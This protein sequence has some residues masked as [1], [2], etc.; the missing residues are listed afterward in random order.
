MQAT[1]P[2]AWKLKF[3][4]RRHYHTHENRN[5]PAEGVAVRMK[6]KPS[7]RNESLPVNVPIL[8]FSRNRINEGIEFS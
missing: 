2:S 5:I 6:I 4:S 7:M 3:P 8:Q 1:L